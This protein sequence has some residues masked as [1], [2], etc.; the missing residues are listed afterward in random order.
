MHWLNR[1]GKRARGLVDGAAVKLLP[2]TGVE[3]HG[4]A[5]EREETVGWNRCVETRAQLRPSGRVEHS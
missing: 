5:D 2:P 3:D 4:E 1:R